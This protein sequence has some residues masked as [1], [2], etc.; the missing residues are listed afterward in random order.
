MSLK[1][2]I[3]VLV[4]LSAVLFFMPYVQAEGIQKTAIQTGDIS[5]AEFND[6]MKNVQEKLRTTWQPPDF[7]EEGHV[8]VFFKLTRQ[9]RVLSAKIIESSGDDIY[10]ESALEAIKESVPFG[11]FPEDSLREFLSVKYSFDTIMIEEE[12]MNGYY[13]LAKHYTKNNPQLALQYLDMAIDRVGGEEAS[14]FLYKRRADI[15]KLLGNNV[16]AKEDYDT[17]NMY[18]N[19]ANIKR[20]HLL[21][22]L[23]ETKPSAY[24]YHYLAY[25]YE[26]VNDYDNAIVAIDKAI[27]LT[28]MNTNLKYYRDSLIAKQ[29]KYSRDVSENISC[30]Y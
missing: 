27:T 13:E 16:G 19:R 3:I 10:D 1:S 9:G 25:A 30:A 4:F 2:P 5:K 17:Y 22:H 23:A 11:D 28:D 14:S 15:R 18:T 29:Q 7:M 26:Q 20:V 8:T 12:R 6:Y 24:I 21:K